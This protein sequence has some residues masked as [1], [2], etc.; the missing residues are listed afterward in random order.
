M[1]QMGFLFHEQNVQAVAKKVSPKDFRHFL[2]NGLALKNFTDLL[3][4]H[5]CT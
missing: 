1:H 4:H 5:R 2:G 3:M